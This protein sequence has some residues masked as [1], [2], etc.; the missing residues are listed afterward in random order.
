[1]EMAVGGLVRRAGPVHGLAPPG[2]VTRT[3][4]TFG[5]RGTIMYGGLQ[6][7]AVGPGAARDA[8]AHVPVGERRT[9]AR[10]ARRA[11]GNASLSA[12]DIAAGKLLA[13][14]G[15]AWCSWRCRRPLVAWA[16]VEGGVPAI[17]V[18][19]VTVVMALLLGVICAIA[20]GLSALLARGTTSSVLS[21]LAVFALTVGTLVLYRLGDGGH[22][23]D[24][25]GALLT[26]IG[27][28]TCPRAVARPRES[29]PSDL[30]WW[31]FAPN[32]FVVLADAAPVAAERP[33]SCHTVATSPL[34]PST[35]CTSPDESGDRPL[36][37]ISRSVRSLR[38][39][40]TS[41]SDTG[42]NRRAAWCGHMGSASTWRSGP[43]CSA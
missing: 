3:K 42:P 15:T 26:L 8:G 18:V 28:H 17:R 14:W 5:S 34:L 1:M 31:L 40:T 36:G 12:F 9:R 39:K 11:P 35:V 30:T 23:A 13:A 37:D 19:V 20:L 29:V 38:V 7:F 16:M 10:H 24:R 2:G 22:L 27:R 21:Y 6:L 33:Q 4:A 43:L 41:F 25:D 32:P